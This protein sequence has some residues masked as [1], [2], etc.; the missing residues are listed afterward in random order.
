MY[1]YGEK[2]GCCIICYGLDG[3]RIYYELH[4]YIFGVYIDYRVSVDGLG[5][6]GYLLYKGQTY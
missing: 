2:M 1:E 6:E 4:V 3:A 5:D